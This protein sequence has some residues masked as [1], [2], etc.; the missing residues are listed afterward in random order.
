MEK[1][2][3]FKTVSPLFEMER[4]DKKCL[5][6]R[7]YD[8]SDK[9]FKALA[10]WNSDLEWYIK[11]I[12]PATSES[13]IRRIYNISYLQWFDFSG[14]REPAFYPHDNWRVIEWYPAFTNLHQGVS[15]AK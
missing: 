15:H 6:F 11:I 12:N 7:E 13:F 1:V 10:Q 5:T 4:D 2:I 3:E 9:R 14:H 8:Y